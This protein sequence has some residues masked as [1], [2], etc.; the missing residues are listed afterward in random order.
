MLCK[1]VKT[2]SR[3][4]DLGCTRALFEARYEPAI[5]AMLAL[6]LEMNPSRQP[7]DPHKTFAFD[8]SYFAQLTVNWVGEPR[9]FGGSVRLTF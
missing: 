5:A 4:G 2:V 8:G 7:D 9:T 3:D 1:C 6:D